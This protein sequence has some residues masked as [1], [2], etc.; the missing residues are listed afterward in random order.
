[1]DMRNAFVGAAAGTLG[2]SWAPDRP[3]RRDYLVYGSPQILQPEID[4]VVATLRSGVSHRTISL[5][6]SP[7]LTDEDVEDVIFA[8][9]RTLAHFARKRKA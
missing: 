5:P 3:V 8:V 1:M 4:Q 2:R 6:L 9:H 7:K